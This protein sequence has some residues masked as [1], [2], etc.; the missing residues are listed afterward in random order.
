[1][2][3]TRVRLR[4]FRAPGQARTCLAWKGSV[5]LLRCRCRQQLVL[6]RF[7]PAVCPKRLQ[8]H[9]RTVAGGTL[10]PSP[11]APPWDYRNAPSR[12]MTG[13]C[14]SRKRRRIGAALLD[15]QGLEFRQ[16][17]ATGPGEKCPLCEYIAFAP[18][19]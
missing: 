9:F 12:E 17:A 13:R 8:S 7:H 5:D 15:F 19:P 1:M 6:L 18:P 14:S 11:L 4:E 10:L 16:A 2:L 3:E